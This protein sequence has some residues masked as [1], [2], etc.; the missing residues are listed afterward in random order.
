MYK[1]QIKEK[2]SLV[3]LATYGTESR[4]DIHSGVLIGSYQGKPMF[5]EGDIL[6]ANA[7]LNLIQDSYDKAKLNTVIAKFIEKIN[8]D[9]AFLQDKIRNNQEDTDE[10]FEEVN[11]KIDQLEQKHDSDTQ[12][13]DGDI[14]H[15]L[16]ELDAFSIANRFVYDGL[17]ENLIIV[18]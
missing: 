8:K 2:H 15:I 9:I 1:P 16:S 3:D 18:K 6:D 5:K 4:K 12:R 14:Q 17:E 7:T 13:I 11:E 10:A